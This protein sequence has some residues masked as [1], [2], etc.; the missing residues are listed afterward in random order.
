MYLYW[1]QGVLLQEV[2]DLLPICCP[3]IFENELARR[4][5]TSSIFTVIDAGA[6]DASSHVGL[7]T[8]LPKLVGLDEAVGTGASAQEFHT[9]Q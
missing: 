6:L 4:P 3:A 8:H 9:R 5:D 7:S 2:I 1:Q